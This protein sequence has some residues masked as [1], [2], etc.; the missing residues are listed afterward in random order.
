MKN[1][2]FSN[3]PTVFRMHLA[4]RSAWDPEAGG[5]HW[6]GVYVCD[7]QLPERDQPGIYTQ[8]YWCIL[9]Q[10]NYIPYLEFITNV[11][12]ISVSNFLLCPAYLGGGLTKPEEK[13]SQLF[14]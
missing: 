4:T 11:C 2:K 8:F 5:D 9:D 1:I 3:H 10:F 12:A 14:I 7:F 13:S 6:S